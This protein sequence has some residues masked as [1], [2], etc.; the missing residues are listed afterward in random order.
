MSVK[1]KMKDWDYAK[2]FTISSPQKVDFMNERPMSA[3]QFFSSQFL[4][5]RAKEKFLS[6]NWD[7]SKIYMTYNFVRPLME[8]CHDDY[9]RPIRHVVF[10]PQNG[11]ILLVSEREAEN[12][13][14]IML[15]K[16]IRDVSHVEKKRRVVSYNMDS[17][18][19]GPTQTRIPILC[20]I[21]FL[22]ASENRFGS[23]VS[24]P[25]SGSNVSTTSQAALRLF[26][27]QVLFTAPEQQALEHELII[28][29]EAALC[30]SIFCDLR[31]FRDI[32]EGS[33][34][35]KCCLEILQRRTNDMM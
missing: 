29:K 16:M 7:V 23:L 32:Y 26:N 5:K 20:G 1:W 33:D 11:E 19:K 13:W 4:S 12:I 24:C 30:A 10:F 2:V 18:H 31:G 27:G 28:S 9:L 17:N 35:E 21:H 6:I 22:I 8:E 25:C 34:L 3:R 14:R 15:E